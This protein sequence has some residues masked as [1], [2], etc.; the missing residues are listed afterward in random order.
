M[1]KQIQRVAIVGGTHGNELTGVYLAKKLLA[2]PQL[3]SRSSFAT[4]V[5]LANP[6]AI[7][8]N[9][10]YVDRDLNRCFDNEDLNNFNLSEYEH[11]LARELAARLGPKENPQADVIFDLHSTTSNMGLSLLLSSYEAFNFQFAAYLMTLFPQ[12]RVSCGLQCSQEAPMLRSLSPL[13]C[14]VEVGAVPQGVVNA[15]LL[16]ETEAIV[17]GALDFVDR[18]NQGTL[19]ELPSK[20]VYYQA[21]EAVDFPRD[22]QG[23]LIGMIHPALQG[24]DFQAL[25]PSDPIFLLFDGE[26]V[27]FKGD[28]TVYPVFINEAAYYEKGVAMV[29]TEKRERQLI[30]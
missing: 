10:R 1:S 19:P 30:P 14:T 20:I 2:N 3:A 22:V 9:R 6:E 8:L 17:F 5:L 4:E 11:G 15:D 27:V 28:R 13:G 18:F 25:N 7:Q 12:V 23:E 24:Q 21:I 26:V 29:L 16:M